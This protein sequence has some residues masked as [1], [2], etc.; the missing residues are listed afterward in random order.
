MYC[1]SD[2]S[3]F[4]MLGHI[5][6]ILILRQVFLCIQLK[7]TWTPDPNATSSVGI[8]GKTASPISI[9]STAHNITRLIDYFLRK[10]QFRPITICCIVLY[11]FPNDS[12]YVL[13]SNAVLQDPN[14]NPIVTCTNWETKAIVCFSE[15]VQYISRPE[16][17]QSIYA[18]HSLEQKSC[19][20]CVRDFVRCALGPVG[21]GN[22]GREQMRL[23]K[24]SKISFLQKVSNFKLTDLI[25]EKP[26]FRLNLM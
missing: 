5:S 22:H 2:R 23:V 25:P 19:V 24:N 7:A 20:G 21:Q 14:E 16:S 3:Q 9:S 4:C 18:L 17:V 12:P 13:V 15:S 10:N 11:L 8:R 26:I 6:I 1:S